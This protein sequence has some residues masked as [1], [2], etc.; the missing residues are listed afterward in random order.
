MKVVIGNA[1]PYTN[2][3]LHLGRVVVFIPGDILARYHRKKGDE[4][5]FI[6][7]S[8]TH[9]HLIPLKAKEEGIT[10]LEVIDKYHNEF[11][12]EFKGL[13]F[14]FD[15][16]SNTEK[17][18]HKVWAKKSILE[19]Y[20]K[21][22]IYE[23]D[24]DLY[25]KLSELEEKVKNIFERGKLNWRENAKE[26]T[27]KYISEGLRD[28]AV[29]KDID[30][31]IDVPLEGFEDK[32]I[33]VWIEALMGYLTATSECVGEDKLKEYIS[34]S[35]SRVYLVHG[36][37]NIPFHTIIFTGLLS[38]LGHEDINLR[39]FSSNHLKLEGKNFSTNKNWAL[40]IDDMLQRYSVDIIRYFL[41]LNSPEA[42]DTDFRWKN[43]IN[44]N[45]NDLVNEL[46]RFCANTINF[47]GRGKCEIYKNK[48]EK[49]RLENLY[50]EVGEKIESGKFKDALKEVISFIVDTNRDRT[51]SLIKL[52]NVINILEIFMPSFSINILDTLD[53]K[54][55]VWEFIHLED[56]PRDITYTESFKELDKNIFLDEINRLKRKKTK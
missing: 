3:K 53:I 38:A 31:G 5:L 22:Y 41:I 9:G 26:I 32:K 17:E 16:F 15:L 19:F 43:F 52:V 21:G 35:D 40:W 11:I 55:N 24:G 10:P 13:D 48:Y 56:V 36:K 39:V 4:V 51:Y 27:E 6:S 29:T 18:S 14:S 54:E 23:K 33:F 46:Q 47:Y 25:F 45:N 50:L 1:W 20:E 12:R 34:G 44:I 37:D 49:K 7:G 28:R 2:S 8:D 30:F 42:G